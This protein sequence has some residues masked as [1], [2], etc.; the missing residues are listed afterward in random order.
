MF[1]K[2]VSVCDQETLFRL[3]MMEKRFMFKSWYNCIIV[4]GFKRNEG[5]TIFPGLLDTK[6]I[7]SMPS[8]RL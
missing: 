4:D 6:M 2:I 1:W 5:K 7:E 3:Y 8:N